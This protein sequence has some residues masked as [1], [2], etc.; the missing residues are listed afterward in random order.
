MV[1]LLL[2]LIVILLVLI[3][4]NKRET[5]K[6]PN[7]RLGCPLPMKTPKLHFH[8][9]KNWTPKIKVNMVTHHCDFYLKSMDFKNTIF[10]NVKKIYEKTYNENLLAKNSNINFDEYKFYYEDAY[11]NF[12]TYY[13]NFDKIIDLELDSVIYNLQNNENTQTKNQIIKQN[14]EVLVDLE[15][16]ES[17]KGIHMYF[18]PYIGKD[19]YSKTIV[20]SNGIPVTFMALYVEKDNKLMRTI[21]DYPRF[22]NNIKFSKMC[23]QHLGYLF[24]LEDSNDTKNLMNFKMNKYD[25]YEVFLESNKE[26]S[27]LDKLFTLTRLDHLKIF[28]IFI[29]LTRIDTEALEKKE[30]LELKEEVKDYEKVLA[31]LRDDSMM[32]NNI[33]KYLGDFYH[34]Y[35]FR[36]NNKFDVG[37]SRI[38][39]LNNLKSQ[40]KEV[41]FKK[42]LKHI[43]QNSHIKA[44][45]KIVALITNLVGKELNL[46]QINVVRKNF[47][48]KYPVLFETKN[49]DIINIEGNKVDEAK[50][51]CHQYRKNYLQQHNHPCNHKPGYKDISVELNR[52]EYLGMD[53]KQGKDKKVVVTRVYQ[54]GSV[55]KNGLIHVGDIIE[56][57]NRKRTD[58]LKLDEI[59]DLLYKNN[60]YNKYSRH[61]DLLLLIRRRLDKICNKEQIYKDCLYKYNKM[62]P[63]DYRYNEIIPQENITIKVP[64]NCDKLQEYKLYT[65]QSKCRG[66]IELDS[67]DDIEENNKC[68]SNDSQYSLINDELSYL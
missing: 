35:F 57:I 65:E 41:E 38:L 34:N 7:L 21:H 22:Q 53:V 11:K 26:L 16:L 51:F 33:V 61:Y 24:G 19:T 18:V 55:Y 6:C 64:N 2:L 62:K 36:E 44:V 31:K 30:M 68:M 50:I 63:A 47:I 12:S 40:N 28:R 5:F 52:G 25:E 45:A 67:D 42:K 46:N 32:K 59:K 39:E 10:N 23:A 27:F 4:F 49:P 1:T 9:V 60:I 20:L 48:D 43:F 13:S 58:V 37:D 15:L 29:N 14:L 3:I 66:Y 56:T 17:K 54:N 8:F